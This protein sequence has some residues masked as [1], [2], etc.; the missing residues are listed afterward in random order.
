LYA[1]HE[2]AS[3][4]TVQ[5]IPS[6]INGTSEITAEVSIIP[7]NPPAN[8]SYAAA[9]ILIPPTSEEFPTPYIYVSNRNVGTQD[10]SGVGD[11]IAIFE[12]TE[13]GQL[14]LINQVFTTIDQI[15][16]MEFGTACEGTEDYLIAAGV[17]GEAGV[18]VFQRTDEGRNLTEVARNT[19]LPTRTSFLWKC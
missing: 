19:E 11:S 8:S 13:D 12:H 2:L 15:R 4:L 7:E 6:D 18:I 1:L 3:T 9:E 14:K 10:P 16:G 5:K 17:A